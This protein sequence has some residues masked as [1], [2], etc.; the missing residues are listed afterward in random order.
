MATSEID[1]AEQEPALNA[2]ETK[3]SA[4]EKSTDRPV[5]SS[6]PIPKPPVKRVRKPSPVLKK[7]GFLV[8]AL[9]AGFLGAWLFEQTGLANQS[10]TTTI[11]ESK[12]R[13]LAEGE[14][15]SDVAKSV[16]PS[17]VSIVTTSTATSSFY[18]SVAQEGAGTGVVIS[19]NGYILTNKH[20]IPDSIQSLSIV[21]ADGKTYDSVT[22]VGRDPINDLAFLKINGVDNLT[23]AT[24]G[25]STDVSVGQKVVAIG[26]A[27]GQYR[28]TVTSGI[29]S[30]IG[31]PVTAGD[32]T[33]SETESLSNLIQTDAAINP[34][35]SGG[36][37]VNMNNEVIGINVA[38]A[39]EAQGI[40]FAI[41]IDDAKGL[42]ETVLSTGKVSRPYIGVQYV[43]LDKAIARQLDIDQTS[44]AYVGPGSGPAVVSGSPAEKAGLRSG[45]II[46]K[47]NSTTLSDTVSLVSQVAK[48]RPGDTITLTI[49]R[50]GKEQQVKVTLD[51]YSG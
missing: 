39:S 34:G 3:K 37:L 5:V 17:V 27:L 11:K 4:V 18:G 38:V 15:V 48:Y 26:N 21:M 10:T 32:E 49:I 51:S 28:T 33:G 43:M 19:K 35:N 29:I 23:P 40:G 30:G 42:I 22:V 31:R 41:P 13:V 8:A 20:V 45:D 6:R 14:V 50:S 46:T 1:T 25:S 9:V 24:L 16:S 36:P 2:A 47:V 7:S 12:E 44:G